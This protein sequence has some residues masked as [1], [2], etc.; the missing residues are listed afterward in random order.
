[1][2]KVNKYHSNPLQD[3]S[4]TDL[5]MKLSFESGFPFLPFPLSLSPAE[6]L[7]R[8]MFMANEGDGLDSFIFQIIA[9]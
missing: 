7:K 9:L 4:P 8:F 2:V 3:A 1:M 5:Q 6:N